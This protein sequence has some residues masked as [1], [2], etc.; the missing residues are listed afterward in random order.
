[1]DG[2][3]PFR[4]PTVRF[5]PEGPMPAIELSSVIDG[6]TG[7]VV[8]SAGTPSSGTD[9]IQTITFAGTISSG[10]FRLRFEGETTG[11]ITWSS[12]NATLVGNIDTALE[13]LTGIG[14]GGVTT[15]VGTM[16]SG[17]GTITV[18]FTGPNVTKRPV[19]TM[20]VAD[21][22]LVG[23][24]ASVSVAETTPGV[25]A[26]FRGLGKGTIATDTTNALLYINTNTANSPTWTKVGT[27]T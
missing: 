27:Q 18:T 19:P 21:N 24:G 23:S 6:A 12:T 8:A 1:M 4:L 2:P 22:S 14:S 15:A 7:M 25:A 11:P 10:T 26:S 5:T 3:G 16:T 20:A 17:I 13:A 9:E